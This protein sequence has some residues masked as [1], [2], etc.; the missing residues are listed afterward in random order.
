MFAEECTNA[1]M[2][3]DCCYNP[4]NFKFDVHAYYRD[5]KLFLMV[6]A[7]TYSAVFMVF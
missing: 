5:G 2:C 6:D 7:S 3:A 1:G 4:G